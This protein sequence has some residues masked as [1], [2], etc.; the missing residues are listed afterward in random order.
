MG[1]GTIQSG[2]C[3][4]LPLSV[5]F[6]KSPTAKKGLCMPLIFLGLGAFL[7]SVY[8]IQIATNRPPEGHALRSAAKTAAT[9]ALVA[10]GLAAQAPALVVLGLALG[11]AGDFFL[12]RRGETMFLA[13]M[14]A[15]A[16]G[17]LAY[18]WALW[19]RAQE[20]G[21]ASPTSGQTASLVALAAIVLTLGLWL[22]ARAGALRLP[23]MAYAL[24]IGL[25]AAA[26]LILPANMGHRVIQLGAA[27]FLLSD[28]LLALRLFVARPGAIRPL[29]LAV[30]PTY[31]LGQALI[32]LGAVLYWELPK[33]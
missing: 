14:A 13:G 18:V 31:W 7:A 6:G 30:W 2:N 15:F 16:G 22:S 28:T 17:H 11:A 9:A 25:M 21:F 1:T 32:L 4:K 33:G 19:T 27:L 20:L 8:L 26:A 3:L 10:A 24:V 23:V 12:S 5:S 29:E